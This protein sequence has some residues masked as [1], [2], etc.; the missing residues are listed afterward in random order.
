MP[1]GYLPILAPLLLIFAAPDLAINLL[2]SKSQLY[3]IYY[4]Y[5]A[6]IT[7]FLF[8]AAIYAAGWILTR[9]K[10]VS[11][12]SLIVYLVVVGLFSTY[13][14]S[15]IPGTRSPNL[16][17]ITRP[18]PHK[19]QIDRVLA[20]IPPQYSVSTSN[21]LGSHVAR[22]PYVFTMPYGWD[23]ADYIIF[24]MNET[25]A[26]PS[27]QAHK[28]QAKILANNRAYTKYY[29]DGIILA[30]RKIQIPE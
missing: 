14:Y 8:I 4:Q 28:D 30:F 24:M 19:S 21:S 3:Q 16:D 26:Y 27:L 10:F 18:M 9:F 15:P 20:A 2:S 6:A 25:N 17:M 23:S 1:L 29:D 5:T 22:R 12:A 13:F 7:P 11:T